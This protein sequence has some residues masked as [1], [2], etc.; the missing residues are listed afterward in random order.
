MNCNV[1]NIPAANRFADLIAETLLRQYADDILMLSQVVVFVPNRRGA[2]TIKEAF[3]RAQGLAPTILP[4]IIPLGDLEEDEIF[5]S[6]DAFARDVLPAVDNMERHLIFTKIILSKPADFGLQKFSAAQA[7][8]LA[9]QLEKLIDEAHNER[10]DFD[11]LKNLVPEKYA[12]HWQ[13]TLKFLQIVTQ[14]WPQIL[15]EKNAV[16]A[17][18]KQNILLKIKAESWEENKPKTHIISAGIYADYPQIKEFLRAIKNLPNGQIY[19]GGLDRNLSDEE[20]FGADENH[21][22]YQ[23]AKL[24]EFLDISRD[25]VVDLCPSENPQRE[26]FV[27]EVMRPA[28]GSDKWLELKNRPFP[29]ETFDGLH[30]VSCED[31]RHEALT[32]ALIMREKLED[33]ETRIALVSP[34]R[35]LA[36][37]VASELE[38]WKITVDDTAGK[39]LHLMPVAIFLRQ[40]VQVVETDFAG[41][42]FLALLK[43]PLCRC[44]QKNSDFRKNVRDF[45]TTV[46][47]KKDKTDINKNLQQWAD[48]IK[49]KML[50]LKKLFDQ[51]NAKLN[52]LIFAHLLIAETLAQTQEISGAGALWRGEEGK[53]A[54]AFF[55]GLLEKSDIIGEI[56]CSEYADFLENMMSAEVV[57]KQYGTH[58]RLKIMGPVEARLNNFDTVIIAEVNEG[59]WPP[60]ADADP[61]MSRPMKK[62]FGLPLPE[63]EVGIF[64]F[65]FANLLSGQ[66]VY[67]ARAVRS[68]DAPTNKSRWLLRFETVACASGINVEDLYENEY[69]LWAKDIE[70][71]AAYAPAEAPTP[72]PNVVLRPRRFSASALQTLIDNPYAAFA[73]YI[74]KLY[75]LDDIDAE[76]DARDYGVLI[77]KIIEQFNTIYNAQLPEDAENIYFSLAKQLF[78]QH[79]VEEINKVFWWAKF[80]KT[81]KWILSREVDQRKGIRRI[82]SEN[83]GE[84]E[85]E[86]FGGRSSINAKADRIDE[87]EDGSVSVID[88]KTGSNVPSKKSVMSYK[89]V[90]LIVEG[91]IAQNG[92]Y[93]KVSSRKVKN[94]KYWKFKGGEVIINEHMESFLQQGFQIIKNLLDMYDNPDMAYVVKTK[95]KYA[96]SHDDYEHLCRIKEW[97]VSGDDEDNVGENGDD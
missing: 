42:Q 60:S 43:N 1:F 74:L 66:N 38:R 10:L 95:P 16:D 89:N 15:A 18:E 13:E 56:E 71:A 90:Q 75:P 22:Q 21:P 27:S 50:P 7:S 65:D 79:S 62:E 41:V 3:V 92:G 4:R 11:E 83:R 64:A 69:A 19:I 94:L 6:E 61:W 58:P 24:L 2:Q 81:V 46:L 26:R 55:A 23:L 93:E 59:V 91:I 96:G 82:Y 88:Y 84:L 47:R 45:E 77:H 49:E 73:K 63:K 72:R 39:P 31:L 30:L 36:R 87:Y 44:S 53:T 51:K 80:V 17:A 86:L 14:Y 9:G 8:A 32:I 35:N 40:I 78:E 85:F 29:R 57:R 37:M 68:G 28:Q 97:G 54:S 52:D 70:R 25:D 33:K 5:L 34:D 12:E 76:P 48:E 20:F 67:I